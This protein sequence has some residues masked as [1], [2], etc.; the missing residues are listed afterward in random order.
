V[1]IDR[2]L[3]RS[4]VE[5]LGSGEASRRILARTLSPEPEAGSL[6]RNFRRVRLRKE[7]PVWPVEVYPMLV[8]SS[9]WKRIVPILR[10]KAPERH[11]SN[12]IP[13]RT[14]GAQTA[15]A[16]SASPAAIISRRSATR[17]RGGRP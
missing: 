12:W 15:D 4:Y 2:G 9:D 6:T 17:R 5:R 16:P 7:R 14:F 10:E 13:D 8:F 1:S 11:P 3:Y